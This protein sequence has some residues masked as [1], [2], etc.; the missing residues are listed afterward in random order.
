MLTQ[1]HKYTHEHAN[2]DTPTHRCIHTYEEAGSIP[3]AL[4]LPRR[5][6][7]RASVQVPVPPNSSVA[8]QIDARSSPTNSDTQRAIKRVALIQ[9]APAAKGSRKG[10][11]KS[12]IKDQPSRQLHFQPPLPPRQTLKLHDFIS[13]RPVVKNLVSPKTSNS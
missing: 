13:R 8:L 4:W 6:T 11:T 12:L 5:R 9:S 10:A 7:V 2:A 3:N 1:G